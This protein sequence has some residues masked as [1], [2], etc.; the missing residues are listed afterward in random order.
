[1]GSSPQG[2][3][4]DGVTLAQAGAAMSQIQMAADANKKAFNK[5]YTKV[6]ISPL[7]DD[8]IGTARPWMLMLLG[9]VGLVLLIA[10]A[11]VANLVLAHGAT[12][13]RELTVRSAL[14][15]KPLASSRGNSWLKA[16]SWLWSAR[17]SASPVPGG[18]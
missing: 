8:Y 16:W 9:A 4:R 14:G 10:C 2:R 18:A 17:W 12:R 15:A 3:L 11:N 6:L 1:M 13:V 7:L 5:G